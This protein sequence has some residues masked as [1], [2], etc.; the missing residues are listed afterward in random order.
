MQM[1]NKKRRNKTKETPLTQ[2]Q[3]IKR[4]NRTTRKSYRLFELLIWKGESL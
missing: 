2:K 3:I 4:I 1:K